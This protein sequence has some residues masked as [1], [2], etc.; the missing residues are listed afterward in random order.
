VL[1]LNDLIFETNKLLR[2]LIGEDIELVTLPAPNM[3]LVKVDPSQIE[4]VLMNMAV[5]AR[6]AMPKGGTLTIE[7][8][9]VLLD[10]EDVRQYVN[11]APGPYVLLSISDTG[12]GMDRATQAHLFEPFFTTKE[13]GQGT[14]LGLATCYGIVTQHGGHI[15]VTSEVGCG[16]TFQIYLPRMA[17]AVAAS[18]PQAERPSLPRGS[19]L[20]LITEDEPAVRAMAVRVL[21]QQGYR[22]LEAANG[23]E[24]L[25]IAQVRSEEPIALLVTDMVMPQMGGKTL[26]EQIAALSPNVKVL[27]MSGYTDAAIV[28]HDQLTHGRAF[29][30]KP[31]SSATLA[32]KVRDV[33]DA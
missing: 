27:F 9:N 14:G 21:R 24:A 8:R 6:H 30:Q 5:N 15:V 3:G 28:Q 19:E 18:S 29:L 13:P 11:L 20:V 2:R 25:R 1:N 31:F 10:A 22:V 26:A 7:T 23:E 4:Q 33:L 17:D 16:T 12:I 32:Q